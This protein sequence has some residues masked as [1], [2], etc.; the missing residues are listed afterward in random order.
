MD[1]DFLKEFDLFST[2]PN[3]FNPSVEI[4]YF[5]E[6]L[7]LITINVS[8]I[9]GKHIEKL[10]SKIHAPGSYSVNWQPKHLVPS[11]LYFI[12]INSS[13]INLTKKVNKLG[14]E[15]ILSSTSKSCG[16]IEAV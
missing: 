15:K 1:N 7:D 4:K 13:N 3:P 8:D 16:S 2:Y 14:L 5:I 10:V 6:S 12:Q 9:N 11:G